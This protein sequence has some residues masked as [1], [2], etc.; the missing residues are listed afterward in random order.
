MVI[1]VRIGIVAKNIKANT[2]RGE[3]AFT[4]SYDR[5]AGGS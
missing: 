2:W 5:E 4:H 1:V 3:S